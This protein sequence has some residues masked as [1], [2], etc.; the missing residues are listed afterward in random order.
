MNIALIHDWL[1][2]M[3]GAE[4]VVTNF[5][6]IFE[7]APIYTSVYDKN[8]LDGILKNS[9]IKASFLQSI[10]RAVKDHRKF[11]PLMPIAFESFNLNE[12]DVILSSSSSCA[13]GVIT[14]PSTCHICYCHSPMR[15]GWEFYYDYL[16]S[17]GKIK[18]KILKY[19][20]NY[21][22]IWDRVSSDRVDYFIANSKNVAKRIWK[23]YRRD[24]VIIHPPVRSKFFKI[25]D[26]QDDYF[27]VVSRLQ[28][29]KKIDLVVE[30][31][32]EL[33][34]PLVIIG[35]GPMRVDIEKRIRSS[36]IKMLGRQTDE[37][38]RD[39]YSRARGF[40]FPGEEDFGITP[41][42]AQASGVPVIA[43]SKGGALETVVEDV[44]GIF[45]DEQTVSSLCNAIHRFN[46]MSFNKIHIRNHAKNFDEEIFK[47]KIRRFVY[48]KSGE[49]KR[50]E[51]WKIL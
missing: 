13:K 10:K 34:L 37:V 30:A 8:N 15:Y 43:Y 4:R 11:F 28:E 6:E 44:T 14:S 31:F 27:L 19:I 2:F 9:N 38:I 32:N 47:D 16:G 45:F 42:E 25:S 36:A 51:K 23:H 49:F 39:Y 33:K 26:H 20:M 12:Y 24:S 21:M 40:L 41:L 22:R 3:G 5:L 50:I 29:Y 18:Q 17:I 35:D 48:E 1:P 46:K 7:G